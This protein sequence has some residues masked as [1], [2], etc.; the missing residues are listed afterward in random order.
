MTSAMESDPTGGATSDGAELFSL[1]PSV[2]RTAVPLVVGLLVSLAARSG[3]DLD[4]GLLQA[5]TGL[6]SLIVGTGYYAIVR[7]LE[8]RNPSLGWLLG[9]PHA[10]VYPTRAPRGRA[11]AADP[12]L[13]LPLG[14]I[15]TVEET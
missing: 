8:R 5:V 10:P 14:S 3:L 4:D 2:I 13:T 15:E 11:A 9:S 7:E 12:G 1:G 6:V